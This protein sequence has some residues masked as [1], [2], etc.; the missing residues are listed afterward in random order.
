MDGAIAW[1][2][3]GDGDVVLFLHGLGGSRMAWEPQIEALCA[4]W[5]CVAWDMPG[6]GASS[7]ISP[8]TFEAVADAITGLLDQLEVEGAHL[9]G[10]SFGGHH[11]LHAALRHPDRVLSLVLADTSAVFGGD[12]TDPEEWRRL[13]TAPLDAG[14]EL[15]DIADDVIASIAAPGFDGPERDRTAAAMARIP[16]AGFRA[17]CGLLTT[18][19]VRHRLEEITAPSLV[20]VGE[21]DTETPPAYAAEIAEGIPNSRLEVIPEAGHLSP[22]EAPDIFNQLVGEFLAGPLGLV[23][24]HGRPTSSISSSASSWARTHRLGHDGP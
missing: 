18:H 16:A 4:R 24:G 15:A 10:L 3:A 2:E 5:R 11:A 7:P 22:A 19:D 9:C 21:L 14:L 20:I 17:A 23:L 1:R 13:R 12:G 8:L 6:Y